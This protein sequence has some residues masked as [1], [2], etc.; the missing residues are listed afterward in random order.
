MT[1]TGVFDF[2][3]KRIFRRVDSS[4]EVY[5][6]CGDRK[7]QATSENISCGGIYIKSPQENIPED[8]DLELAIY[9]P[10]REK[11]VVMTADIIR[12]DR[13]GDLALKFRGL[14]DDNVLQIEKFIK[15]HLN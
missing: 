1:A 7:I 14:Y 8:T 13:S 6:N 4:L 9:L 2:I 3:E 10:H 5:L 15:A 11:P 12:K